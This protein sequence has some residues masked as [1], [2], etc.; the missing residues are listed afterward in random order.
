[1]KVSRRGGRLSEAGRSTAIAAIRRAMPVPI[2]KVEESHARQTHR[3]R[4]T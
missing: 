4:T 2:L 3:A 1:V